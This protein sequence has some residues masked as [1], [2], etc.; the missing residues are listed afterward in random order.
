[1]LLKYAV[2]VDN[3]G[4]VCSA[5]IETAITTEAHV[6]FTAIIAVVCSLF[7]L[8]NNESLVTEQ[9]ALVFL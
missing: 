2:L 3:G 8:T 7:V 5:Q 6:P 4:I 1:V 9:H